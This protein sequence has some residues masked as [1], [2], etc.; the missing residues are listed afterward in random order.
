MRELQ[1]SKSFRRTR[2]PGYLFQEAINGW[3]NKGDICRVEI[4]N[5]TSLFHYSHTI[6]PEDLVIVLIQSQCPFTFK[7]WRLTAKH[8]FCYTT[9]LFCCVFRKKRSGWVRLDSWPLL[10]LVEGILQTPLAWGNAEVVS[11]N[12]WI[13]VLG[14][15]WLSFIYATLWSR[16]QTIEMPV[17]KLYACLFYDYDYL[18]NIY[19]E[20]FFLKSLVLCTSVRINDVKRPK[21]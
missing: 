21:N 16:A 12:N 1:Q 17:K 7:L 14:V 19:Y 11:C 6:W 8:H 13:T 18:R 15:D 10:G 5:W 9:T 3:P 20:R 4:I 2:K